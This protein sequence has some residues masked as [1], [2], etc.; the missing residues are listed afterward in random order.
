MLLVAYAAA[1]LVVV[2]WPSPVD[3]K[4]RGM[5]ARILK[6]LHDRHLLEFLGYP[7][8]EFTSN[9]L[10]FVPL[11]LLLGLLLGRR[12]WG[13]SVLVCFA[14]SAAI[15]LT[16]Y[17]FLPARFA[18]VDDVI[19]NTLGGLLGAL[20]SGALL[21]RW[22]RRRE[23]RLLRRAVALPPVPPRDGWGPDAVHL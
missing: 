14:G 6:G 17:L 8:V 13:L 21:A 9:V 3:Q 10:L 19:A 22:R 12:I 18:T 20:A 4:A 5:L 11:G 15:E 2:M 1:V 7:Q 23:R 16:Q